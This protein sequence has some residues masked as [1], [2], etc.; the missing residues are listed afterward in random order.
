M[1]VM[2]EG[3]WFDKLILFLT[4]ELST[5]MESKV[6]SCIRKWHSLEDISWNFSELLIVFF[7]FEFATISELD[8]LTILFH[9]FMPSKTARLSA[10]TCH[11]ARKWSCWFLFSQ[12]WALN[13]LRRFLA[14]DISSLPLYAS[15]WPTQTHTCTGSTERI[16]FWPHFM[17]SGW[18]LVVLHSG[19]YVIGLK[20]F[21][22][23]SVFYLCH[24]LYL[25]VLA[26]WSVIY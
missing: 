21:S 20:R 11:Y 6:I 5:K 2:V 7:Q 23:W 18:L 22:Y 24:C 9:L 8:T 16:L 13:K 15:E 1:A 17:K 10:F 14:V 12:K 25:Q 3:L 19:Y 26:D 4:A